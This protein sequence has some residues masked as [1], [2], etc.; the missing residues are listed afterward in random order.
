MMRLHGPLPVRNKALVLGRIGIVRSLG[1]EGIPVIVAREESRTFERAS[2]YCSEYVTLPNLDRFSEQALQILE[3]Y[4]ERQEHKPVVFLNAESDVLLVSKSRERLQKYFHILLAPDKL[5]GKLIDKSQFGNLAKQFDLPVPRT[6]TPLANAEAMAYA[7]A[8]GYPCILKPVRQRLWHQSEI[9]RSIGIRKAI[10]IENPAVLKQTL[11]MIPP[12]TGEVMIQEYIPG[13]DQQHFDFHAYLDRDGKA[14]GKIVGHKLRIHPIHFGAGCYVQYAEEPAIE[15]LCLNAL[16]K[17]GYTGAANINLKRHPQTLQDYILEINP[18]Y[19]LWAIF[20]TACGVNLPLLHYFDA[21]GSA[22]PEQPPFG[23]SRR[24]LWLGADFA[25]MLAYRK[26]GEWTLWNWLKSLI[27]LPGK[28]EYHVFAWDDPIPLLASWMLK[29]ET[30]LRITYSYFLR[31]LEILPGTKAP[32]RCKKQIQSRFPMPRSCASGSDCRTNKLTYEPIGSADQSLWLGALKKIMTRSACAHKLRSII[33][34]NRYD[35]RYLDIG[36]HRPAVC[37]CE[38]RIVREPLPGL[39][40]A[41]HI[42]ESI[43]K[44]RF[45][46]GDLCFVGLRDGQYLGIS[47]AHQGVCFIKGAGKLLDLAD[48]EVYKY[49]SH[50]LPQARGQGVYR[51]INDAFFSHYRKERIRKFWEM[52]RPDN[53]IITGTLSR[54][55]WV[56]HSIIWRVKMGPVNLV[57]E[58]FCANGKKKLSLVSDA[59]VP[60]YVI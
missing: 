36:Y 55:G 46:H 39:S 58:R 54:I 16:E 59:L 35:I 47:W 41:F 31:G 2:R 34:W 38:V 30:N 43:L 25:A 8:L 20:D 17:I 5:I 14:R 44:Y 40:T 24:W 53:T 23:K 4:G 18:R 1:R 11:Q 42:D 13:D 22:V 57:L 7:E 48:D 37:Q 3:R 60:C 9:I 52:N 32:L 12:L 50:T 45:G 19:S 56:K 33:A 27:F 26:T 28:I 51:S 6:F 15:K 29:I 49:G 21:V 10:R